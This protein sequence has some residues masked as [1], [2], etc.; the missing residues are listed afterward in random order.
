[1][2]V[3]ETTHLPVAQVPA[4]DGWALATGN[5][6]TNMW[7]RPGPVLAALMALLDWAREHTSPRD[8]NSPHELLVAAQQAVDDATAEQHA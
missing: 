2:E 1:M 6:T 3:Y 8:P 7:R 4:G 5:T